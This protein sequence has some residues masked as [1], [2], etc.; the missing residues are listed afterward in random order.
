M[1]II[2]SWQA[3]YGPYAIVRHTKTEQKNADVKEFEAMWLDV[4]EESCD[5][6]RREPILRSF[7]GYLYS[8]ERADFDTLEQARG[9]LLEANDSYQPEE[10]KH[11]WDEQTGWL[12]DE[13]YEKRQEQIER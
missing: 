11:D 1:Q 6:H 12:V 2:E 3:E 8:G 5:C 7:D 13:I 9:F 4:D 10:Y